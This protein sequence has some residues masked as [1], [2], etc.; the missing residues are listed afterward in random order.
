M[1]SA[2]I[3]QEYRFM[4]ITRQAELVSALTSVLLD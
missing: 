2:L 4:L 1:Q 3:Y